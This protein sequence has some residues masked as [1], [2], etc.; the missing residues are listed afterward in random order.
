MI[1]TAVGEVRHPGSA[2]AQRSFA[3]DRRA[4]AVGTVA[5]AVTCL[6]GWRQ[7]NLSAVAWVLLIGMLTAHSTHL[8]THRP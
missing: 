8:A 2:R 4:L 1:R 7:A 6:L 3:S 5:A